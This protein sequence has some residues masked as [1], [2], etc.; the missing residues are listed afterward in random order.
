MKGTLDCHLFSRVSWHQHDNDLLSINCIKQKQVI[1]HSPLCDDFNF[2]Y[3]INV[4][5]LN[6]FK[7]NTFIADV[8][9]TKDVF[10]FIC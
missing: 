6:L 5:S 7:G 4:H 9:K 10:F 1:I 2:K 3:L 8:K